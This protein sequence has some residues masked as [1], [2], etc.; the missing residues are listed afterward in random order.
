M[1]SIIESVKQWLLAH[2]ETAYD[3]KNALTAQSLW[4]LRIVICLVS[5]CIAVFF[6]SILLHLLIVFLIRFIHR[7]RIAWAFIF[8]TRW[9]QDHVTK[10]T[11]KMTKWMERFVSG[12]CDPE[13]KKDRR[14]ARRKI[15]RRIYLTLLL[16]SVIFGGS[17]FFVPQVKELAENWF[18]SDINHMQTLLDYWQAYNRSSL[19]LTI[20]CL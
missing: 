3:F 2:I 20:T 7:F 12:V 10:W 14:T 8:S 6:L 18:R 4:F 1:T 11:A 19:I 17:Y 9:S 5:V 13:V 15:R 16:L